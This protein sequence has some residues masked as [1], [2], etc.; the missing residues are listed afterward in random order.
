M[1]VIRSTR[2]GQYAETRARSASKPVVRAA[3][4]ARSINCSRIA[5]CNS[6]LASAMSVPGMGA[7]C[8]AAPLAVAVRRGSTTMWVAP[9]ARPSSKYC[10]AGGMVSAGFEPDQ[11]D[12]L[13]LR[14]VGE[15]ERQP[16]VDTERPVGRGR[17]GRHAEPAV[18][19]D[20][21]GPQRHPGEL[22]ELVG[23]LVGQ[24]AAAE[25][26]H[27]VR[28]VPELRLA[29]GLD[30][31]AQR[32]IPARRPQRR[33]AVTADL[34][35]QRGQQPVRV[36][37][38]VGCGPALG[39]QPATVGREVL[40]RLQGGRAAAR[41]HGDTA[42]EAA[43]GAVRQGATCAGRPAEARGTEGGGHIEKSGGRA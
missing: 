20:G 34:P 27:T 23:L 38:Q 24:A 25:A 3:M 6:P 42:L 39:A 13:R 32:F 17:R 14:D 16:P 43:V 40:L 36:V 18:V 22:A 21:A 5:M 12:R 41:D 35:D 33:G 26:A 4:K 2:S 11:Q 31:A 30:D 28:P 37:E 7:R 10:M 9:L 15:R 1:P 29:D 19:V 8:R